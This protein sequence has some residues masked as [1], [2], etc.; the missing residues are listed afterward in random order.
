MLNKW[1][2]NAWFSVAL[3]AI[4]FASA[5]SRDRYIPVDD[6]PVAQVTPATLVEPEAVYLEDALSAMERTSQEM[7]D[8]SHVSSLDAN[9]VRT[10]ELDELVNGNDEISQLLEEAMMA[11]EQ[12]IQSLREALGK[13]S[14]V[15][16]ALNSRPFDVNRV[17]AVDVQE[18]GSVL[19][20]L[21]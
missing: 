2:T 20:F 10:V 13:R 11:S 21:K 5:N 12:T 7:T 9:H 18:D 15:L 14:E 1:G 3:I 17:V 6:D 19:V 8:L 16:V 4:F